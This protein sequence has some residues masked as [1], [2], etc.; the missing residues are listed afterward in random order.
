MAKLSIN[1]E[2]HSGICQ[3]W[4][5]IYVPV[6]KDPNDKDSDNNDIEYIEQQVLKTYNVSAKLQASSTFISNKNIVLNGDPVT[7]TGCP[8]CK[9]GKVKS[10]ISKKININ[11]KKPISVG[12]VIEY[13]GGSITIKSAG[14]KINA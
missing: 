4:E 12:D 1:G 6:P 2:T 9:T 8:Y 14:S 11:G 7:I 3:H 13:N 10:V 5:T